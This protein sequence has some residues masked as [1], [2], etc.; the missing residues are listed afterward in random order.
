MR[1]RRPM[2]RWFPVEGDPDNARIKIRHLLPGDIREIKNEVL[3]HE[4]EYIDKRAVIRQTSDMRADRERLLQKRVVSWENFFDADGSPVD[5]TPEN[6]IRASN[7]I[8]GFDE[9][10]DE[11]A[12]KL[13]EDIASESKDQEK[14]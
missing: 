14:N 1:I 4:I 12:K 9:L 6:I 11:C 10:V 5:C 3:T 7:E 2:E 8:D 13:A